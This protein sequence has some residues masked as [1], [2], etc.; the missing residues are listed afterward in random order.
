MAFLS[1]DD[2]YLLNHEVLDGHHKKLFEIFSTLNIK[3]IANDTA[4]TYSEVIDELETY[5]RYHFSKEEQYMRELAYPGIDRHMILHKSYMAR[6]LEIKLKMYNQEYKLCHE[7]ILFLGNWLKRHV[8]EEDRNISAACGKDV[9]CP[10]C[11]VN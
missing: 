9:E 3:C 10:R 7:L 6:T 2:D 11:T 4:E 8:L 1:W 5:S